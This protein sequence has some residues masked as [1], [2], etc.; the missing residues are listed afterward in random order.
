M[1]KTWLIL[2]CSYLCHRAF[3]TMRDLTYREVATGVIYG[4]FRQLLDLQSQFDTGHVVFCFDS[5][6]SKRRDLFPRYKASRRTKELTVE[7]ILAY[8]EMRRQMR[9]LRRR[10]LPRIGFRNVF[11]QRG[12][13]A[14]DLIASVLQ[15]SLS[16]DDEAIVVSAD[17]DLYQLLRGGVV[18]YDPFGN[19]RTTLQ[20]FHRETGLSPKDWPRVLSL[21]GCRTDEVPGVGGVGTK[22]AIEYL[23]NTLKKGSARWKACRYADPELLRRNE[24]LTRLPFEGTKTFTLYYDVISQPGWEKTCRILGMKSLRGEV[25]LTPKLNT[26]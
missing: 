19:Q 4:F 14:D 26:P 11:C 23:K 7:E 2:D 12:H 8:K 21:A 15:R 6:K 25:P 3:H 22:T 16:E 5:R 9:D 18:L 10:H 17:H 13:E 1:S 24:R 20:S